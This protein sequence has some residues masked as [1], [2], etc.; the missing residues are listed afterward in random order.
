MYYETLSKRV[1]TDAKGNDR[2]FSEKFIVEEC[3]ICAEAESKTLQYWNGENDVVSVK[4]SK[5]REF[6]NTR[7]DEE[8]DIYLATIEDVF[9]EEAT[10]EEKTT[11]YVVG[12][13]AKSTPEATKR[14]VDYM[15]Q[16]ISD[17]RLAAIRRT[18]IVELLR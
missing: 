6:V 2:E 10:G 12:L 14:V 11:K 16:G 3:E 8:Q 4:Q 18:N 7:Q 1:G 9:V 17:L 5:I 13:F 15:Q